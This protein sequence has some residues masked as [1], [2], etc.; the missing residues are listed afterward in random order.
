MHGMIQIECKPEHRI[1]GFADRVVLV[2]CPGASRRQLGHSMY[3]VI[4]L[5]AD[6]IT[7][8]IKHNMSM[9]ITYPTP[10]DPPQKAGNLR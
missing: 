7:I 6:I 5:H 1:E 10:G 8:P 3:P 2:S 9:E 4:I